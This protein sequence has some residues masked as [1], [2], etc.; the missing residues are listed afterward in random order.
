ML[1]LRALSALAVTNRSSPTRRGRRADSAGS[2][3]RPT[4][5]GGRSHQVEQPEEI[6]RSHGQQRQQQRGAQEIGRDHRPLAVPAIDEDPGDRPEEDLGQEGGGEDTAGGDGGSGQRVG[7]KRQRDEEGEVAG[8]RD[9][10]SRPEQRKITM[11]SVAI[12]RVPAT[13]PAP[14]ASQ[15]RLWE[16]RS[17]PGVPAPLQRA[18]CRSSG[19]D[20]LP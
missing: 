16:K 8:D 10:P 9:Q 17:C 14:I 13:T 6:G 4:D 2:K 5:T 15:R 1:L 18:P 7:M 3:M 12:T 20:S 11:R 19:N